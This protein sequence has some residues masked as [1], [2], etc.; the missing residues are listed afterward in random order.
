MA[1]V[2]AQQRQVGAQKWPWQQSLWEVRLCPTGSPAP[3]WEPLKIRENQTPRKTKTLRG[4]PGPILMVLEVSDIPGAD[5]DFLPT[6]SYLAPG[7]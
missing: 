5:P 2:Q 3:F 6:Q 7:S 4:S 1:T